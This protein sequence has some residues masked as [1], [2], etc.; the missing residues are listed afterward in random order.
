MSVIAFCKA[1]FDPR[2]QVEFKKANTEKTPHGGT[3]LPWGVLFSFTFLPVRT[4]SLYRITPR[5]HAGLE[6]SLKGI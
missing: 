1:Q 6:G 5:V 4:R 2:K 3:K